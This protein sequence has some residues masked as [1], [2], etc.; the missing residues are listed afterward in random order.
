MYYLSILA[1]YIFFNSSRV[2]Y[3][4]LVL[5]YALF[6]FFALWDFQEWGALVCNQ[7]AGRNSV[8][9]EFEEALAQCNSNESYALRYQL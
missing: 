6:C 7:G 3:F 9:V 4:L 2:V 1:N 5:G 8:L